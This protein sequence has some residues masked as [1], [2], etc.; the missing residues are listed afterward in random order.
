LPNKIVATATRRGYAGDG[1]LTVFFYG[2]NFL[3]LRHP[4]DQIRQQLSLRL[5]RVR[6]QL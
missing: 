1:Q 6:G 3:T 4:H 5:A 2:F